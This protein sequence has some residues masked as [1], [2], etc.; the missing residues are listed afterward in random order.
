MTLAELRAKAAEQA[1]QIRQQADA[2]NERKKANTEHWPDA[3]RAAWDAVNKDY[4]DT[5]AA[6]KALEDDAAMTV[7]MNQITEDENRSTRHGR[8]MPGLDDVLPGE[9]R[10]YGEA[11]FETREE[12]RVHAQREQDKRNFLRLWMV[13]GTDIVMPTEEMRASCTRLNVDPASAN[14]NFRLFN[15]EQHHHLRSV[16]QRCHPST[17]MNEKRALSSITSGAGVELIPTSFIAT[18]ELAMIAYG[19]L[20]A[21]V[22]TLTTDTGNPMTW[23]TGDDTSNEGVEAAEAADITGLGEPDPTIALLTW[24]AWEYVSK[25]IRVPYSLARDSGV[26]IDQLVAA[27]IGERF[28]RILT[29]RATVGTGSSQLKG[30][31]TDAA[32]GV[33]TAGA[34]AIAGDDIIGLQQSVDAA[35]RSS[36]QFMAHDNIITAIRKLKDGNSRYLWESNIQFGQPDTLF[37]RPLIPNAYMA[38]T[39]ATTNITMLYGDFSH[40]KLRRVGASKI[41]RAN[42]RFI[43]K[44]Q[45]AFLGHISADGKLLKTANATACPV[46]KMTQA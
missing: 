17:L 20:L 23:P 37:G 30:V 11:G 24:N 15:S 41:Y 5:R 6:I 45:M 34:S 12:A 40:Y 38:S 18:I 35:Y 19:P 42:E 46:K 4:D 2:Y 44:L 10:T 36:G 16:A 33:T 1:K 13:R 29:R 8:Q 31:V 9:Q 43:E 21:Y 26:N 28:G 14:L 27:F 39:I 3:T 22:D 7:R 32:A 25:F